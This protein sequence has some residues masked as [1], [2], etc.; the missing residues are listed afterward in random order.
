VEEGKASC[1]YCGG[2]PGAAAYPYATRW[3]GRRFT[4]HD[5][6]GCGATFIHPLPSAAELD[7]LFDRAAYHDLY[8]AAKGPSAGQTAS[9]AWMQP[10]LKPGG[11]MLDFG[12][13]NGAFMKLAAGA[14]FDVAGVEQNATAIA[15]A[16]ERSGLP[17][18]SLEALL[19][20][21]DLFDAIHL[22]DVLSHL[23]RPG[24]L[25]R[26]LERLLAPGG[27]LVVEGP[28]EKQRNLV[29][30]TLVAG[31]RLRRTLARDGEAEHPPLHLTFSSWRSQSHF[32]AGMGYRC[33]AVDL[34]EDAWPFAT[35]PAAG[36]G[37]GAW[38]KALI[39][40]G[41]IALSHSPGARRIGAFNRFRAI[42]RPS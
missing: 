14:G 18:T 41:A 9:L 27:L 38:I 39:G 28:L 29:Y 20:G 2:A 40:R 33:V 3:G 1:P 15:F 36:A 5:C 16:A 23:P 34:H 42:L 13:G 7:A 4:Y 37:K 19:A 26:S 30:L 31:K 8:Y 35:R 11:R 32:F 25:L 10:Y 24:G 17:V 6:T 12:C 21:D 22:A